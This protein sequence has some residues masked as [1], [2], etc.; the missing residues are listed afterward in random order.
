MQ[1]CQNYSVF[2]GPLIFWNAASNVC[3]VKFCLVVEH[4]FIVFIRHIAYKSMEAN[5]GKKSV[6]SCFCFQVLFQFSNSWHDFICFCVVRL[7]TQLHSNI[8]KCTQINIE[9]LKQ[10]INICSGQID[11]KYPVFVERLIW[12]VILS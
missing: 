11:H 10:Q 9:M 5:N 8:L 7:F 4:A 2:H 3:E 6:N 12:T 1:H